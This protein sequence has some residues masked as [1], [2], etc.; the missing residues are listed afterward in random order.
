MFSPTFSKRKEVSQ[1][2]HQEKGNEC[3]VSLNYQFLSNYETQECQIYSAK[4]I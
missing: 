4:L 1:Q 2:F 3:F